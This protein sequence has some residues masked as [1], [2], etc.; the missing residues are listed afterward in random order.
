[1]ADLIE[2]I[3]SQ[4]YENSTEDISGSIMQQVLTRMASDEGV[5]NVHTIS[6]QTPFADYNNAQA[7]RDAVPA[8]FKKL[9]LIITYKL[10][11]GWYIDEFIGSATS[12]W[13]TASNW[14][15][16]GP[17][18]VSQNAST[19]KTTI[20]IGSE[21][22]DVATQPVS[23]SQNKETKHLDLSIGTET[24][25]IP[26][27]YDLYGKLDKVLG[28]NLVDTNKISIGKLINGSGTIVDVSDKYAVTDFIPVNGQNIITNAFG[29]G[30]D[31]STY[32]V[33]DDNFQR[34]RTGGTNQQYTYQ[35]GDAFIKISYSGNARYANYGTTLIQEP[36][37]DYLPLVEL[38]ASVQTELDAKID[39]QPSANL[40]DSDKLTYSKAIQWNGAIVTV[41]SSS[42]CVSDYIPVNGHDIISNA[43]YTANTWS[44]FN[45]YDTN[46][47]LLRTGGAT[48]QYTYQSGDAYVIFCFSADKKY[49]NYGTTLA[50]VDYYEYKPLH[51]L[52]V[53]VEGIASDVQELKENV[54]ESLRMN[55]LDGITFTNGYL[56]DNTGTLRA[57]A[58]YCAS[59]YIPVHGK[60]IIANCFYYT[61]SWAGFVVYNKNKQI[62]R[63]IT[64]TNQ[65]TY[66]EGDYY[67]RLSFSISTN[68]KAFFGTE[69]YSD[70]IPANVDKNTT[71]IS[72]LKTV[73]TDIG[74]YK[75]YNIVSVGVGKD[76]PT[77]QDAINSISDAT[78][79]NRY[80]LMVYDDF[81]ITQI[82]D[83]WLLGAP[84]I[85]ATDASQS[86]AY[87]ITKDYVDIMGANRPVKISV[88]LPYADSASSQYDYC[89]CVFEKGDV[90]IANMIFESEYTR[91]TMHEEN[92]SGDAT[93]MNANKKKYFKNVVFCYLNGKRY[94]RALGIGTA[95]GEEC[96]YENCVMESFDDGVMLDGIGNL[97]SHSNYPYPFTY[98]FVNC[99]ITT[100]NGYDSPIY[101]DINS[102][103]K[104]TIELVG[105]TFGA[106]VDLRTPT[107]LG[108]PT[109]S[110][111]S[112]DYRK[113][114][115]YLIGNGNKGYLGSLTA[116]CVFIESLSNDVDIEVVDDGADNN[117]FKDLIGDA[118]RVYKG[119]A[120]AKG[121]YI[122]SEFIIN[123]PSL[124]WS[125]QKRLGDCSS[126]SKKL[127]VK[128][129]GTPQTIT[130]SSDYTSMTTPDIISEINALL[131]GCKIDYVIPYQ[132]MGWGDNSIIVKNNGTSTIKLGKIVKRNG[133][134]VELAQSDDVILGVASERINPNEYGTIIIKSGQRFRGIAGLATNITEGKYYKADD[135]GNLQETI[136]VSDAYFVS[137][138]NGLLEWL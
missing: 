31:W 39:K 107:A 42:Y 128:V 24:T 131:S 61:G 19:G 48:Q 63:T 82:T 27:V 58:N 5:V 22:Y 62:L 35:D 110:N 102:G 89:N 14:K 81:K 96:V 118:L 49:A 16:L 21:S 15:C 59:D 8:G 109:L 64:T 112:R 34:L 12:G 20:T 17:I 75:G 80:L 54:R 117:V 119:S 66:Q 123:N 9:G 92:G 60:D 11:S 45:V 69:L 79:D 122:G 13:S 113:G 2:Y 36:Y 50:Q 124:D 130:L 133:I 33:Y 46:K 127:I 87:I 90:R 23:V 73:I 77:I 84:T 38:A 53:E 72:K 55:L 68:K 94:N 57:N 95:P 93:G 111:I 137:L 67:V 37:T 18:S 78:F 104:P 132:I 97:H 88:S 3:Q 121:I 25:P 47:T 56:F 83:L 126:T 136:N 91:Y 101:T 114:G 76:Y 138:A 28:N 26:S 40:I 129:D 108:N 10:S 85:H 1:M 70:T 86:C 7:A 135:N 29:Y 106:I 44:A 116:P 32:N 120:D 6:G 103:I 134:G 52:Q 43:T 71:D 4:V 30:S 74:T 115:F 41:G 125:I 98:R 65:Y 99:R 105:C 51:D 100:A